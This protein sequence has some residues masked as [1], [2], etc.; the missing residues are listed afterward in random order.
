MNLLFGANGSG[1]TSVLESIGF[2]ATGRSFR[3]IRLDP[4]AQRGSSYCLVSSEIDSQI[5]GKVTVGLRRDQS[6]DK[7]LKVNGHN[8]ARMSEAAR[9]LPT[10]VLGPD[11][12]ELLRGS[13]SERRKFMN[14]GVFHVEHSFGELWRQATRALQQ[15]NNL[16]RSERIDKSQVDIWTTQLAIQSNL[17]DK[18]RAQYY[19]RFLPVFTDTYRF[20]L[21]LE[22][23]KCSYRRGWDSERT[24]DQVLEEQYESDSQRKFTQSGFQRADLR[25]TCN[26]QPVS[27]ICS[28]GELKLL[29]WAAIL[30]QGFVLS[31]DSN[32]PL[33]LVDDLIAELD[34][35]HQ[36]AVAQLLSQQEGQVLVTGT[37]EKLLKALWQKGYGKVFHVEQGS[38]KELEK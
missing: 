38:V 22:G 33:F 15:R 4:V 3:G 24:L 37:D 29:S 17:I 14:Q 23:V 7:I 9:H 30:A 19:E 18:A 21:D 31:Q 26:G 13:P 12:V 16:L 5:H 20:L 2:L 1:K 32:P 10:L 36:T 25:F 35:K 8:E 27:Q 28:R 6:G 11:S 34:A